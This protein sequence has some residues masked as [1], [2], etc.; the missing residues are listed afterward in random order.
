M[1]NNFETNVEP[2]GTLTESLLAVNALNYQMPPSLGIATSV[3]HR[4][5]FAQMN[6]Y[7]VGANSGASTIVFDLQSGSSFIDPASSYFV[8]NVSH[9]NTDAKIP[10]SFGSGS[11]AN[12]IQSVTVRSR[13]GRE[14]SRVENFNLITKYADLI[15][16][17]NDRLNTVMKAQGYSSLGVYGD[18]VPYTGKTFLLPMRT[19]PCFNPVNDKQLLPPQLCEGMRI[20]FRLESSNVAFTTAEQKDD[21]A[22]PANFSY[23]VNRPYAHYLCFDLAD[24]FSRQIAMVAAKSGLRMLHKEYF[25]T[26]VST[27]NTS[28]N[29]DIKKAASK[30]LNCLIIERFVS[31]I[32]AGASD[33]FASVPYDIKSYQS[34][35]GSIYYPNAPLTTD[36]LTQD[37]NL[38]SYY[39]S[40]YGQNALSYALSPSITPEQ[41]TGLTDKKIF[42]NGF[43]AFNLNASNVSALVGQ[44]LN[45]SRSFIVNLV[46]QS[47]KL[48]R[49]DA[50]LCHLRATTVMTS[51]VIVLD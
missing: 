35:I 23:T 11:I 51:N 3:R 42:N 50:F 39:Y 13:T 48:K 10:L 26:L 31:G 44:T 5:E 49:F 28:I 22:F 4:N 45:N 16:N 43:V 15:Q 24:A 8:F 20:E 32:A 47:D 38:E 30:A 37:G 33:C 19:I 36:I 1:S 7:T 27:A 40:L 34:Q 29:F 6:S 25:H 9:N 46:C 12:I 17:S 21:G 41:W 18:V 14:L 2:S